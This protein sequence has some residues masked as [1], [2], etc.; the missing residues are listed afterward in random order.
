MT[1]D[2]AKKELRYIKDIEKDIKSVE[3]EI[4]RLMATATKMTPSY[5]GV[6][7]SGGH[8]DKIADTLARVEDFRS[9]LTNLMNE[10]LDAKNKCIGKLENVESNTLR[11]ILR[12]YFFMDF[13]LE[14][15][16][17]MIDRSYKLTY[18]MY[19]SA[20]EEYAEKN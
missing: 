13:T 16:A 17:E 4:E 12:Y 14:K 10:S 2:E 5:D 15:T 3:L 20:I 9:R 6:S 11:S 18:V 7:S 8:K 19:Q 1:V